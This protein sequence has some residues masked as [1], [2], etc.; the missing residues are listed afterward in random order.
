MTYRRALMIV[1]F[2]ILCIF[3]CNL[4]E[5]T[6]SDRDETP[7]E[8]VPTLIEGTTTTDE[9][10]V[11]TLSPTS[12]PPSE[13]PPSPPILKIVY[14][15]AG[16]IWLIE[17]GSPPQQLTNSGFAENVLI[18]PDG[19][20]IVF[21][22]RLTFDDLAELRVVNA[23]GS[24]EDVLLSTDDMKTLYP[25]TLESKGFEISQMAFLPGTH[26]L[27]FNTYEA[28]ATIG[29][30][31]TDD[32][33]L[34]NTDSGDLTRLLNP[35]HG[36]QFAISPDGT[37]IVMIQPDRIHLVNP[38]GSGLSTDLINYPPVITYSEF[39][40][41][42]QPIWTRDSGAVGFAIPSADPLDGSPS[43][44][45]WRIPRDGSAAV[46]IATIAGDFYFSQVFSTTILSP[47]FDRVAF[48]RETA[49]PNI[50]ELYIAQSDGAAETIYDTGEISWVGWA[51]D[52]IHFVYSLTDPMDLII[53][54]VGDSP[55]PLVTGMDLRWINNRDFLYLSGSMGAWTLMK[56]SIGT[57]P[58]SL[59]TPVGDFISYDFTRSP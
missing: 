57:A 32:L 13:V 4:F 16:N 17:G 39:Q 10:F 33:L 5:G 12:I 41:Y 42:A 25:S 46:K 59:V 58:T 6:S 55:A 1:G 53:G 34:I 8:V 44:D 18:S 51:P 29:V 7:S 20:K 45:I 11:A 23:D 30:A 47:L 14:I 24:G 27:Y 26:D 22:R 40:Y 9:P 21:K 49:T 19:L 48:M 37:R 56:G 15:D 3:S 54:S 38:D 31:M 28:F 36:G 35:N 43:G 50:R 52:G 2:L